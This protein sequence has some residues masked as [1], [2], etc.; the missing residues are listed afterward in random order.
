MRI[1]SRAGFSLIEVMVVA[2]VGMMVTTTAVPNMI[3]VISNM[4]LR[5]SM[6]SLSGVLQDGRMVAVKQNRT[7]SVRFQAITYGT[8]T[9]LRGYV[10]R[11]TDSSAVAKGDPQVQLERPITRVTTPSGPGAPTALDDATLGFTPQTGEASFN[12]TG[13]PC[14][15]SS[16][17]CS[18]N[19]FVY[20]FHDSRPGSQMGWAALSSSPAGRFKK[21]YW[22]GSGWTD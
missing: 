14:T 15:Y 3:S 1:K 17:L 19:G 20:Y 8:Q 13:L 22:D 6:T 5:S 11:A 21:W 2:A 9:G 16:G 7:M 10:K 12:T 4:R 18:N